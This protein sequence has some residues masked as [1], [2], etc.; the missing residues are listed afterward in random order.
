MRQYRGSVALLEGQHRDRCTVGGMVLRECCTVGRTGGAPH[1]AAGSWENVGI[2]HQ[3][4]GYRHLVCWAQGYI[5]LV[6]M[7]LD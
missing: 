1:C 3:L 7:L 6:V 2:N 4:S 5:S